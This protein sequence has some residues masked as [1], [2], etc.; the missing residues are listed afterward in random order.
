LFDKYQKFN[1]NM[2]FISDRERVA[3]SDF[4]PSFSTKL[5]NSFKF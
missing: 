5:C 4:F 3:N 1:S 2:K